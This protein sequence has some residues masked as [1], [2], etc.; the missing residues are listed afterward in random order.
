[1]SQNVRFALVLLAIGLTAGYMLF[2]ESGYSGEVVSPDFRME[3]IPL[4]IGGWQGRVK[5]IDDDVFR[6]LG[7]EAEIS[8]AY[9]KAGEPNLFV[10]FALWSKSSAITKSCPHHPNSCYGG[11]GWRPVESERITID[12]TTGPVPVQLTL[13]QRGFEAIVVAHNYRMG[14]HVFTTLDEGEEVIRGLWGAPQWPAV[15]KFLVQI[16]ATNLK[17]AVPIVKE[18]SPALLNWSSR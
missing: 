15:V 17:A 5:E 10:H 14:S 4:E 7:A 1:M 2:A 11:Q 3:N 13:F 6:V 8:A 9:E 12:T 16:P 18:I